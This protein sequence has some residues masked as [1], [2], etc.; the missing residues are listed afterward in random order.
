[1]KKI[2]LSAAAIL[3][4]ATASAEV[5]AFIAENGVKE[6]WD[7]E[8]NEYIVLPNGFYFQSM[9]TGNTYTNPAQYIEQYAASKYVSIKGEVIEAGKPNEIYV[10]SG[11]I[12]WFAGNPITFTPAKGVKITEIHVRKA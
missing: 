11:A 7:R 5:T 4:A 8:A 3:V 10:T 12:R 6:G 2:L 9:R 1:M